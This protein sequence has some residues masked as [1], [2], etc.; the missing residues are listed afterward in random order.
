MSETAD[1]VVIGGGV[2]GASIA[3]QLAKQGAG[4]VALLERRAICNGTT[5]RS[6]A[7]VRQHYSNDFTIR[8]AR[9]S[10]RVFQHFDEVVGGDCGF[11]TTGLIVLADEHRAQALRANVQLQ[12]EQGVDTRLISAQEV[13]E[14]APGYGGEGVMLAC[15]E[16][17]TG[18]ADPMATTSC[19][20]QRARDFGAIT[21]EG[22]PVLEILRQN[23]RV[24]G[25]RTEREELLAP[26][27]VL[28]ANVWSAA[29]AE[30]LGIKLPVLPTRHPMLALRRPNDFG[31]RH[32]YH[33]VGLDLIRHIYLRPDIGGMTLIGSAE[34]VL[35]ESDPDNY[36]QS[37]N[38]E[39][40]AHLH[41]LGAGSIPALARAVP[42][43][44]WAG[45]YDDTPDYHPIL[46]RLPAYDGLYCAAGFSG[47]GFKLSPI[48]GQWMAQLI[49]TGKKPADMEYFAFD[50]FENGKEIRPRYPSGVLG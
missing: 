27:V 13:G 31:G 8:M 46:D 47:H 24:T 30:P 18:V 17:E 6:G 29:L 32:G 16:P 42:R 40:I 3:Y 19:L 15:Y 26:V 37:L 50:R 22:E 20:A 4:R 49:L 28:A 36:I 2:M 48:V 7:I 25:A 41:K 1:I 11:V 43:G 33:A 34:D 44:T 38:E 9:D 12:Q 23:G 10:L 21:R 35:T 5:G 39:E 45:I 14:V